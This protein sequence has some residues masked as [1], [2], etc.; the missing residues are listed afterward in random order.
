MGW[1]EIL[2]KKALAWGNK[3]PL[4]FSK[5]KQAHVQTHCKVFCKHIVG[6]TLFELLLCRISFT[7]IWVCVQHVQGSSHVSQ[8]RTVPICK[9]AWLLPWQ[10]LVQS[11]Q[12]EPS[13]NWRCCSYSRKEPVKC[14]WSSVLV[15]GPCWKR[16]SDLSFSYSRG[17]HLT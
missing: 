3:L 9:D 14:P 11:G 5:W 4:G 15:S 2:S 8:E 12:L 10:L 13:L 17:F 7:I 6:L 1:C 16:G